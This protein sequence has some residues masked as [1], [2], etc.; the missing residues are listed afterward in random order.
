[1]AFQF[2]KGKNKGPYEVTCPLCQHKQQESP[3]AVSSY[4]K[5]CNAYLSFEKKGEVKARAQAADD[6]F[7][8]RPAQPKVEIDHKPKEEPTSPVKVKKP[9]A[10]P[11]TPPPKTS[12]K[13]TLPAPPS[14]ELKEVSEEPTTRYQAP[15][16][17]VGPKKP[18]PPPRRGEKPRTA[19]CFECGDTHSANARSNSTQCRKCG[20]LISLEDFHISQIWSSQIQTRGDVYIHKKGVVSGVTIQCHHLIV[21]GDFTGSAECT[22]DL[23]LQR[24][25]KVAGEITCDRLL[26][27]KRA[28]VEFDKPVITNEC[29]ID[30]LVTGDISCR[31]LLALEKKATLTGNIKVGTL[32][33]SEGAKHSGQIQMGAF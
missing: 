14:P 17:A 5:G 27:E 16:P 30:G 1:M 10:L 24:N 32:T 29:Q 2:F 23:K 21:E 8:H 6:P 33:V 19:T 26:V 22:G 13:K 20:R 15:Q 18:P 11:K 28:Q 7:A 25:G 3:L 9:E 31:G 12:P 4:C